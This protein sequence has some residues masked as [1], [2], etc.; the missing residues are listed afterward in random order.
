MAFQAGCQ[1]RAGAGLVGEVSVPASPAASF[2]APLF[3]SEFYDFPSVGAS[4]I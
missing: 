3:C 1:E 2:P 4:G